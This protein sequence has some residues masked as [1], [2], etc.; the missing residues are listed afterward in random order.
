MST[1]PP[2]GTVRKDS[3]AVAAL[4]K[5]KADLVNARIYLSN[6][7]GCYEMED[8]NYS[9]ADHNLTLKNA[10]KAFDKAIGEIAAL[11][12]ASSPTKTLKQVE[13]LRMN[14]SSEYVMGYNSAINHA[15]AILTTSTDET[16]GKGGTG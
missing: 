16:D 1:P 11:E 8:I 2:S 15:L 7:A 6:G 10:L 9:M 4:A 5:V 12:S 13:E 3:D 14:G